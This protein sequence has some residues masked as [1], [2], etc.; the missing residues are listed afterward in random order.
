MPE[1]KIAGKMG[2]VS[3]GDKHEIRIMGVINLTKNSFYSGSVS[4]T[5]EEIE[6]SALKL[7]EEGADMIDIGARSTAPYR[8]YEVSVETEKRLLV[9]A[10]QIVSK[11][12]DLPISIDTTRYE[13]AKAAINEGASTLNDVYGFTQ[14]DAGKLASLVASKEIWLLTTAHGEVSRTSASPIS[15]VTSCL[16][17][18]L[19]FAKIHG[20]DKK[21]IT[22][23]PAIGFFKDATISNVDWNCSIIANLRELRRF[24]RPICVGVSRK[25]FIGKLLGKQY[26]NER[27]NGSLGATAIAVYNGAH[28]IRTHDVLPTM[29]VAKIACAMREKRLIHLDD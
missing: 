18:T 3:L 13:S 17:R 5:K 14:K 4:T 8:K 2:G 16:E 1:T 19:E 28:L 15:R 26:P 22:I 29:E 23:D 6:R 9:K 20:V 11:I 12:V 24:G 21:R 25:S 27:L 7:S 10:L